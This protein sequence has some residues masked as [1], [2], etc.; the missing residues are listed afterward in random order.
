MIY[1]RIDKRKLFKCPKY[2]LIYYID[3]EM[4]YFQNDS[5]FTVNF[6]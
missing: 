5:A 3:G 2:S 4:P 1:T 6:N